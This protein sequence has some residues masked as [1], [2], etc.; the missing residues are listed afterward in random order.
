MNLSILKYQDSF[1][2]VKTPRYIDLKIQECALSHLNLKDM[3]QLRDKLDGQSYY[4]SLRRDII[5]EYAFEKVL[6]IQPFDW[7]KR[8]SKAYQRKQYKFGDDQI[9]IVTFQGLDLPKLPYSSKNHVVLIFVNP[10]YGAYVCGLLISSYKKGDWKNNNL[11]L[12]SIDFE[13]LKSF[14]SVEELTNLLSYED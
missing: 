4:N 2:L 9:A 1:K 7:N 13:E 10:G 3:G 8:L 11:T 12:D 6:G 5:A 14:E